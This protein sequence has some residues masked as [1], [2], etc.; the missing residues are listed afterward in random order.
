M[1][2]FICVNRQPVLAL[3][4]T[5]TSELVKV[6][7]YKILDECSCIIEFIQV[8]FLQ[9]WEGALGPFRLG[10]LAWLTPKLGSLL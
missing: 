1:D 6:K 8:F 9:F 4:I 7:K 5:I 10:K 2:P 3:V